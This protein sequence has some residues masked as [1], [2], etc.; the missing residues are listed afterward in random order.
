MKPIVNSQL[1]GKWYKITRDPRSKES[2]FIEV[3]IY[4]STTYKRFKCHF[5]NS[6]VN[7]LDLL[8]VG[9]EDDRSK[10]LEKETLIISS[11]ND[12]NYLIVK[13]FLF[14]KKFKI[15]LFD[16]ENGLLIISD[17]KTKNISIYSSRYKVSL[18]KIEEC[19]KKIGFSG[20]RSITI[21]ENIE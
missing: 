6:S 8:Y 15:L 4:L 17:C 9:I 16:E 19:L 11:R 1:T 5:S 7:F 14:R 21:C 10:I 3:F 20:S 2:R 13:R 12:T 18:K